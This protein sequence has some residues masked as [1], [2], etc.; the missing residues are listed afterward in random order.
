MRIKTDARRISILRAAWEVFREQGFERAS[1]AEISARLGGSKATLY[2]YFTSKEALFFAALE[3]ALQDQAEQVFDRLAAPGALKVRLL[4][5]ARAYMSF[6][7]AADP[8]AIDR[9]L[10]AE[11]KRSDFADVMRQRYIL[12]RWQR[13]AD[14]LAAE[15]AAGRLRRAEPRRAAIHL[16]GLVEA[17]LGERRLHGDDSITAQ[18]IEIEV[19]EGL[20]A[21]LRAYAA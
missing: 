19:R 6:R 2:G 17:D 18:A 15:M 4:G 13:L 21:F 10:I 9:M 1:M 3:D 14:T 8:V 16:R 7:L 11:A 12:P 20:E 5:F